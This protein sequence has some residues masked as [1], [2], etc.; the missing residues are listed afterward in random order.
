MKTAN[1]LNENQTQR[2]LETLRARF[3]KNM[4]RHPNSDW[5]KIQKKVET[6]ADKLLA[7]NKMEDSGGEPDVVEFPDSKEEIFFVDCSKESPK[8][9]RSL[10][11]DRAAL[12]ARKTHKPTNDAATVAKETGIELLDEDQYRALQELE[13][14]DL[15]TSSWIRTPEKI[16]KLGG[17][18]FC[19]R[20]F[21]T[22][23]TY[24]NGAESYYAARGFRGIMKM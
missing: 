5:E 15:K 18:L 11:Y 6:Q 19:D 22:V 10:C 3:L 16:R 8:N 14:F 7:L 9:R 17:A 13:E 20:R 2:L 4:H 21:D 1:K 12:E 23:F 24:H